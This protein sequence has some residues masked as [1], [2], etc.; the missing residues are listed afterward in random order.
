[1]EKILLLN[2]PYGALGRPALGISLLKACLVEQGVV[3]DIRYLSFLFA[4]LIGVE[5][6]HWISSEIAY[7]ALAGDWTFTQ[8]LYG[9][10]LDVDKR[11]IAEVLY[12]TWRFD[13]L[14]IRRL[15]H[16][17]SLVPHFLDHCM[18]TTPWEDYFMVGFT[19]TFEQN[20]ASL[21]LAKL[22][23]EAYPQIR[24]VFGGANWEDEMGVELHRQFPFVDYVCSGEAEK[25]FPALVKL[26]L[27]N[28]D[29]DVS[30][31]SIDGIVFRENGK[32]I[33]TGLPELTQNMDTLPIPDFS[34]YFSDLENSTVSASIVPILL[35]ET[36]RGCWW[37]A[38][39]QCVFCGLNGGSLIY[40]SKSA[41][42]A[43]EELVYLVDQWNI[44]LVEVVD[45]MLDMSYFNDFL[46]ALKNL[47]RKIS[48][49]YEVK[50]NLTKSQVKCLREAG[51]DRIQPGIESLSDHVLVLMRKGT[52]ALRNIQLLKWCKEYAVEVDW[53]IL[54]GFPGETEMDYEAMFDLLPSIR[55]LAPPHGCGPVRL[56]RFSPYFNAPE[57]YG[58]TNVRP[59]AS[60]KFIYPFEDKSLSRIA[61]C[62]DF[63]YEPSA[64]PT[65][66]ASKVVSYIDDWRNKPERGA[67]WSITQ[68]DGALTL[69]DTRSDA[70]ETQF[71]LLDM[72]KNFLRIDLFAI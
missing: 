31:S 45:N 11:Y 34:D 8:T 71:L 49:F 25:S 19:S 44:D 39:S 62:F 10:R 26:L 7:T 56:D 50:A 57:E 16:V 32:S 6:Y 54:Y 4:E 13:R 61:Y 37:G 27:G 70:W 58:I 18:Q 68:A 2:M 5:D 29:T 1:M 43:L 33:Y 55:F 60:Y 67:L 64:D 22:I 36:S 65:G 63:D 12:G 14:D 28:E 30:L 46:P 21:A 42:H 69:L 53:N 24:V 72:D 15:K 66:F 38:K 52:T 20:I 47:N 35:L 41:E 23:K 51:V 40:R 59:I 9:E 3:C 48:I 17:R